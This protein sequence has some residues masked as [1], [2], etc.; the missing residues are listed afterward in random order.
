MIRHTAQIAAV[1]DQLLNQQRDR[2]A[3]FLNLGLQPRLRRHAGV[4]AEPNAER[5]QGQRACQQECSDCYTDAEATSAVDLE[6]SGAQHGRLVLADLLMLE[7]APHDIRQ[8]IEIFPLEYILGAGSNRFE[9]RDLIGGIG[10]EHHRSFELSLTQC[11]HDSDTI[12]R[13]R[14]AAAADDDVPASLVE[15]SSQVL[16]VAHLLG[17]HCVA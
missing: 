13:R 12:D 5:G 17:R 14:I 7:D 3:A 11:L 10:Q 16:G 6:T 4:H 2:A 1:A 9:V 8:A 15:R